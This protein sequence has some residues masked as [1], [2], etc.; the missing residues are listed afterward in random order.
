MSTN[1]IF[2]DARKNKILNGL[3]NSTSNTNPLVEYYGPGD[4]EDTDL[5]YEINVW[6]NCYCILDDDN[7][8]HM[9]CAAIDNR[10]FNMSVEEL[11]EDN[12]YWLVDTFAAYGD[13][14]GKLLPN[15]PVELLPYALEALKYYPDFK[16]A[17]KAYYSRKMQ[18]YNPSV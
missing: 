14:W 1:C 2:E 17:S 7:P 16:A 11:H 18:K 3:F 8:N 12:V 9:S 15:I 13:R 4:N 5:L 6:A 10:I